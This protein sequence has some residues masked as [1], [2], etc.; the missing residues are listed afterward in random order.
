LQWQL[1]LDFTPL[2][3][4]RFGSLL[5]AHHADNIGFAVGASTRDSGRKKKL[6]QR[7]PQLQP[8]PQRLPSAAQVASRALFSTLP[9]PGSSY[10]RVRATRLRSVFPYRTSYLSQVLVASF[11]QSPHR[12]IIVSSSV[13]VLHGH[14][15]TT[16]RTTEGQKEQVPLTS[17]PNKVRRRVRPE[18]GNCD[19]HQDVPGVP[20]RGLTPPLRRV[21]RIR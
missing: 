1:D 14:P 7:S 2:S 13:S 17:G 5:F 12:T 20:V 15:R 8:D 3:Y 19:V 6:A 11:I 16:R 21:L 4:L 10:H 18:D 9:A